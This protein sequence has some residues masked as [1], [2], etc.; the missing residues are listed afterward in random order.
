[1]AVYILDH[2]YKILCH[3]DHMVEVNP[4]FAEIIKLLQ[5]H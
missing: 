4:T 1:M 3:H 2:T 5:V